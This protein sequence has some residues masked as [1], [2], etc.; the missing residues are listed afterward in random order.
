MD[1][2]PD[3]FKFFNEPIVLYRSDGED[4][5]A[6]VN[7]PTKSGGRA[8][9]MFTTAE[10]AYK[11]IKEAKLVGV[12]VLRFQTRQDQLDYLTKFQQWGC[13]YLIVDPTLSDRV[14]NLFRIE[15]MIDAVKHSM[16]KSS[17]HN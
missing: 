1:D 6:Y 11:F 5:D 12:M 13:T 14:E 17:S 7:G 9:V 10:T 16:G 3:L 8:V 15:V 2:N 4:L